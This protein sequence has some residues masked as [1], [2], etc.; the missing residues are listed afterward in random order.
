MSVKDAKDTRLELD[1]VVLT[2]K[3]GFR[4]IALTNQTAGSF[5]TIFQSGQETLA[6]ESDSN[7]GSGPSAIAFL[8]NDAVGGQTIPFYLTGDGVA[9]TGDISINGTPFVPPSAGGIVQ[10]AFPAVQPVASST[11]T[12][13]YSSGVL[14]AGIYS[15][16][17]FS[18]VVTANPAV[19][20]S[21]ASLWI[22]DSVLTPP[23][24]GQIGIYLRSATLPTPEL[25]EVGGQTCFL[26][27]S[28]GTNEFLIRTFCTTSDASA[29]SVAAGGQTQYVR[30]A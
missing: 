3:Q 4:N 27:T 24:D 11:T 30:L 10:V 6:I 19:S 7:A 9:I 25:Q 18:S 8:A 12:T 21:L 23:F 16:V 17:S 20:F 28:T 29:F 14:P 22:E 5:S 13:I 1:S 26:W 2:G 15:I